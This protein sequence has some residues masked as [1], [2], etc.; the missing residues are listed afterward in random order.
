MREVEGLDK[1]L[2]LAYVLGKDR[3]WLLAHGDE[4]VL[5][6]EQEAAYERLLQ[7]RGRGEPLAYITGEAWFYGRRFIVNPYVLVPRRETE[8]LV[9]EALAYLRAYET[10]VVLDVGTGSGVIA[11]TIGAELPNATVHAT[12]VSEAALKVARENAARTGLNVCFEHADLLPREESIHFDCVIA[13]LPYI[14]SDD[15]P[16]PPDP[17][18]FEPPEAL[19]GGA[20]GLREYRRL[21]SLLPRR[22]NPSAVVLL[23]AA[24][25]TIG[26]LHDLIVTSFEGARVGIGRDYAGLER[27]VS[28][29]VGGVER[30]GDLT[31]V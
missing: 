24:P 7:R 25:P 14:P 30:R 19:D 20:D 27:W 4:A 11:C 3:A 26:A 12:D 5:T 15:L 9:D 8:H 6:P 10:P 2:L 31:S 16:R 18:S 21:L 13:N 28:A 23:E 17:V 29:R 1:T 22:L